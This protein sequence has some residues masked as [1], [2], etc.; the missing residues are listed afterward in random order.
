[1]GVWRIIDAVVTYLY[2][3][4]T[5]YNN[6][7][8]VTIWH[9]PLNVRSRPVP[10]LVDDTTYQSERGV[11]GLVEL[12]RKNARHT[13]YVPYCDGLA[14]CAVTAVWHLRSDKA[15]HEIVVVQ[16]LSA[17]PPGRLDI[18]DVVAL[19][20]VVGGTAQ[21]YSNLAYVCQ[22]HAAALFGLLLARVHGDADAGT[23]ERGPAYDRAGTGR[24]AG[25]VFRLVDVESAA[26]LFPS[27][28]A[29]PEV[30]E[31]AI[32]EVWHRQ[33]LDSDTDDLRT[34][35]HRDAELLRTNRPTLASI[36]TAADKSI[37]ELH[38]MVKENAAETEEIL[39]R[40][41]RVQA[42]EESARRDREA[43]ELVEAQVA[44]RDARIAELEM[45]L[46]TATGASP[47]SLSWGHAAS[48]LSL[49]DSH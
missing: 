23:Y 22:W 26:L 13:H 40:A 17:I 41:K 27:S 9:H 37:P 33:G 1:M 28:D 4:L 34:A 38:Q 25:R 32:R 7:K 3:L 19:A 11:R 24:F 48:V 21:K 15:M 39:L 35:I 36:Q 6:D 43:R 8:T 46:A 18:L 10:P 20:E 42:A 14:R 49:Q 31:D 44:E 47:A 45:Q 12:I 5:P 30:V 2:F 16:T 29:T